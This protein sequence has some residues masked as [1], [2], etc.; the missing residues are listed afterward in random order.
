MS[1]LEI[2]R[3]IVIG[4]LELV[5]EI[6]FAVAN[7][8][9]GHPGLAIIVLSLII[10]ILVLPLYKRADAMQEEARNVEEKL[11][12]GIA[13]IK[14]SFSGDEKMM[15]LQ[16]YYRQNNYKPTSA[17]K[18]SVSL[19]LEIPFFMAA[20]HFLSNLEILNGVSFG[21]IM[22]LGAPDGLVVIGNITVN[23]LPVIMTIINVVSSAIYLKGFPLKTKIQLYAMAAFFLVFLYES[24]SCLVFYW[25]LN[26]VFSL[27][28]NIF[29]KIK[30]PKKIINMLSSVVGILMI[31]FGAILFTSFSMRKKVLFLVIGLLMQG[32]LILS[33]HKD[34][35][36]VCLKYS[37]ADSKIL[38]LASLFLAVLTGGLIPSTFIA[39]SP[40]EFVDMTYFYNPLWYVVNA[41]S[42]SIGTFFV[43]TRV[44][45]W[46][47]N[48]KGK[49]YFEIIISVLTV[50]M[51]VNYLFFGTNLGI[52]SSNLQYENGFSFTLKEQFVNL[53]VLGVLAIIIYKFMLKYKKNVPLILMVAV[54]A[55]SG[56]SIWNVVSVNKD[57]NAVIQNQRVQ[58]DEPPSFQLSKNGKN[59]VVIMFDRAMGEY[60]PYIFKEK[61]ELKEKFAGFT[62]YANTISFGGAT[63]LATPALFG[64][65]EYTPVELNKR[66]SES[67]VSKH[68]E[69]LK[70]MPVIF[71]Q[72]GYEVTVCDPAY[73]NYQNIPDLSIFDEYPNIK[74]YNTYGYYSTTERVE[75]KISNNRRNFFCFG[76][77]KTMPLCVQETI[78]NG[79]RYNIAAYSEESDDIA[80][81]TVEGTSKAM[82]ISDTFMKSYEVLVNLP[83]MTNVTENE[84]NT[85][86]YMVND[87]TH[88]PML[89]QTPTYE[90]QIVVDNT[91]YDKENQARFVVDGKT[92]KMETSLQAIHYHANMATYLKL[93][94]WFDYLR[95]NEVYDNTR[96][97]I[98]SDHGRHLEHFSELSL[99]TPE[100]ST[101]DLES[102]YPLLMVKDFGEN[103]FSTSQ[104]FMTNADVPTIATQDI[105]E[106]I[107][108]PFTGNPINNL[109]KTAHEQFITTSSKW[110]ISKENNG[111]VFLPSTWLSVKDNLW[112]ITNWNFYDKEIVLD[113]HSIR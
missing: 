33:F 39:A 93:G 104:E 95:E 110:D 61:P 112:D 83:T 42:L 13:H 58:N 78:Y 40:L 73:A 86:M 27:V 52:I 8:T 92:L 72:N 97:I 1:F 84:V 45:Y 48:E 65:Y 29:Y 99:E 62:Y 11:Q 53:V 66:S 81:Q 71:E 90:P 38:V 25:T 105:A 59:V 50:V 82:G 85:F 79:G 31:L 17:L 94:E 111:N 18:G 32:P 57:V 9:I 96:I 69:A 36:N 76:V 49:Y 23:L 68:N 2:L 101:I 88:E 75:A 87:T 103:E 113:S 55:I 46:L 5:F 6:I 26:N 106:D 44:F 34:K 10:N 4:P 7:R 24:P 102:F 63:N 21:P 98:V 15:I 107:I 100:D 77:M 67:L 3:T 16:T 14:K 74:A 70:V 108:N 19:L 51:L 54:L 43:W 80:V 12:K 35:I 109:E 41:L 47:A 60:A 37:K 91:T 64:G 56:M 89:L 28:K 22:D 20:Y 30:N